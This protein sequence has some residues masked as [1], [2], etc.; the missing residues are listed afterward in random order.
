LISVFGS[1]LEIF[2][3]F[4]FDHLILE[5][6]DWAISMSRQYPTQKAL[7]EVEIHPARSLED[8]TQHQTKQKDL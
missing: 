8:Q 1:G 5:V 7:V 3:N 6:L 2:F 4:I